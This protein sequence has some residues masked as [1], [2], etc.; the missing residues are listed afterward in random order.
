LQHSTAL[1]S[2]DCSGV[3]AMVRKGGALGY[4]EKSVFSVWLADS[5]PGLTFW[6][7]LFNEITFLSLIIPH[8]FFSCHFL[9]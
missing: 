7:L 3:L 4:N 8:E 5:F 6:L 9:I 1:D 2:K